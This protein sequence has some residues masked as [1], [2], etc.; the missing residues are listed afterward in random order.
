MLSVLVRQE[1]RRL[2][3]WIVVLAAIDLSYPL[4]TLFYPPPDGVAWVSSSRLFGGTLREYGGLLTL[5]FALLLCQAGFPRDEEEGTL[6][7][8]FGLPVPRVQIFLAR[9][10]TPGLILSVEVLLWELV[11]WST[12][13]PATGSFIAHTFRADWLLTTLV[14]SLALAWISVGYGQLLTVFRRFGLLLAFTFYLALSKLE[15]EAPW[16]RKL[17]PLSVLRVEFVG[18]QALLPGDALIGHAL[19]ALLASGLAAWFWVGPTERVSE[20]LARWRR[21]PPLRWLLRPVVLWSCAV[22]LLGWAG[23]SALRSRYGVGGTRASRDGAATVPREGSPLEKRTRHHELTYPKALAP[24]VEP[25]AQV[26]DELHERLAARLGIEAG[27]HV[28]T[29]DFTRESDTHAGTASSNTVRMDPSSSPSAVALERVFAHESTHVLSLRASALR[30]SSESEAVGFFSE[31]L[32]EALALELRPSAAA[33]DARRLEAVLAEQ[34]L[35]LTFER[36]IHYGDFTQRYGTLLVYS[37]GLTW[38]QALIASCGQESPQKVLQALGSPDAPLKASP[39]GLWQ[40]L[41]QRAGCDLSRVNGA[42]ES[43]LAASKKELEAELARV[44]FLQGGNARW[45]G[46]AVQLLAQADGE[47]VEGTV[48]F[49][50]VRTQSTGPEAR[51]TPVSGTRRADGALEFRVPARAVV[52]GALQFQ[53]RLRFERQGAPVS[54]ANEWTKTR[55]APQ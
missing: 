53:L 33:A 45:D 47:P 49:V 28:V 37:A 55:V 20:A 35:S 30:L 14:T 29:V 42:W 8:L 43:Q 32:A 15:A 10:L 54:F 24:R 50:N 51:G 4:L 52:D 25:L 12:H 9:V 34:R 39:L 22:L 38:T 27:G 40:H 26:A 3:P 36:M 6:P 19:G 1:L 18:Q 16:L 44:P 21:R 2:L 11:R 17:D 13:L 31:G 48:F 5:A 7:F 46:D 23:V 41:L